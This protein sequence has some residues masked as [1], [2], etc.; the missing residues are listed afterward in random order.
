MLKEFIPLF[1]IFT[2]SSTAQQTDKLNDSIQAVP[3]STNTNFNYK[4]LIIPAVLIGYGVIGLESDQ[5]K[6]C[7]AQIREEVQEDIDEKISIDDF[8]QYAPMVSVYTLKVPDCSVCI[9]TG[10]G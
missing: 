4:Q 5:L 8:S 1:L 10:I 6:G 3:L 9:I 7:N 2:L